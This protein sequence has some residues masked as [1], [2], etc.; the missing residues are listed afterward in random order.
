MP[1][2]DYIKWYVLAVCAW[3]L[4]MD[5]GYTAMQCKVFSYL[6]RIVNTERSSKPDKAKY[7]F[8]FN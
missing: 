5:D 8:P 1:S 3:V 7:K 2:H 6:K 4:G